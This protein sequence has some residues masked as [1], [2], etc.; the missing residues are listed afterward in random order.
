MP[1]TVAKAIETAL[2]GAFAMIPV[3]KGET[4]KAALTR[5][6]EEGFRNGVRKL[7]AFANSNDLQFDNELLSILRAG[8][9]AADD[10][11]DNPTT[12]PAPADEP[13][14]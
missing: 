14:S 8:V 5:E 4:A 9:N 10:E 6:V 1:S 11:F 13:G 2:I 12:E 3:V 7:R